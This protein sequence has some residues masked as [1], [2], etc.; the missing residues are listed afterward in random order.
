MISIE[1]ATAMAQLLRAKKVLTVERQ[2]DLLKSL[3][4][5]EQLKLLA[6]PAR[7]KSVLGSRRCGKSFV[8]AIILLV[9]ALE[10]PHTLN[11]FFGETLG[12]AV[13]S[14]WRPYIMRLNECLL[15]GGVPA[16]HE[17]SFANGSRVQ[18]KGL[19]ANRYEIDK[20][21]GKAF[22]SL[23]IDEA[24]TQRNVDLQYTIDAVVRPALQ[25]HR[26]TVV[27]IGTPG[28]IPRDFFWE[29]TTG[30]VPG[31]SNHRWLTPQNPVQAQAY[32]DDI[33]ELSAA[34]PDFMTSP[35]Y[36]REY[37]GE[38]CA[39]EGLLC[40]PSITVAQ[41]VKELPRLAYGDQWVDVIAC[42]LG[43]HS[44]LAHIKYSAG[45]DNCYVIRCE[46]HDNW[47]VTDINMETQAWMRDLGK[48]FNRFIIDTGGGGKQISLELIRRHGIPW[49]P[50][51]KNAEFKHVSI[52][53]LDADIRTGG[54]DKDG[55]VI[56]CLKFLNDRGQLNPLLDQMAK[57]SWDEHALRN[58]HV[59]RE[60]VGSDNHM[61]DA[62]L[63]AWRASFHMKGKPQNLPLAPSQY[64][65]DQQARDPLGW[66]M[67]QERLQR[68]NAKID[69]Q[70]K[71]RQ[72]YSPPPRLDRG[73]TG[74]D[75]VGR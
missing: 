22:K 57:L 31:W 27:L 47:D 7:K 1:Q 44:A 39:D 46:Q 23:I 21:R 75:K 9:S 41:V 10:N 12:T 58:D 29:V 48:R 17:L 24:A 5:S 40:Y 4:F 65:T 64:D 51:D 15:L 37:L 11:A 74:W 56:G 50:T 62:L 16:N 70:N 18:C 55:K 34:D 20:I 28:Q 52:D 33:A 54:R 67:K 71:V 60:T 59:R 3:L 49:E 66:Q 36:R 35:L 63:Y 19:D 38:W 73:G 26:G 25:D 61:C 30:Q 2:C 53:L 42:D 69:R 72:V 8:V 45:Q 68:M 43:T 14:V 6:D 32:Y 13:D